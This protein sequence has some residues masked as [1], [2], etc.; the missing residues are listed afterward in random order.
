MRLIGAKTKKAQKVKTLK[1][2]RDAKTKTQSWVSCADTGLPHIHVLTTPFS[3][4]S[5]FIKIVHQ[6]NLSSA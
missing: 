5:T 6:S 3:L 2:S 1:A 4:R